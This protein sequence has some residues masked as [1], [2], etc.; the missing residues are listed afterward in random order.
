MYDT[1]F[2]YL[3]QDKRV[4]KFFL[5]TMLGE[6]VVEAEFRPQEYIHKSDAPTGLLIYRLD[7]TAKIKT[8]TGEYK[9]VLIEIQKAN[10]SVDLMRFRNYLAEHY[11]KQEE[12]ETETGERKMTPLPIITI[13]ILGFNLLNLETAVLKVKREYTDLETG[14]II[15]Q[16]NEFIEKLSHDCYVI[17]TLRLKPKMQNKL[18]KLLSIFEQ[19]NFTDNSKKQKNYVYPID[20]EEMEV[21]INNLVKAGADPEVLKKI[22]LEEEAVRTLELATKEKVDKIKEQEK[23]LKEK[24]NIIEEKDKTI[25]EKD[26]KLEEKDSFIEKLIKENEEL[27]K[28]LKK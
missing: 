28:K 2:K 19:N 12:I 13:Y 27:K 16:K 21:I 20:D 26:K 6:E 10:N 22:E 8:Q 23:A 24:E 7:F 4:V 18:D 1:V 11:K 14:E 9:N 3:M 25:E 5:S 17:Q 15:K